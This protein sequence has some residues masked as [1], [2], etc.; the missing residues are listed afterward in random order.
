MKHYKIV[1]ER[2]LNHLDYNFLTQPEA[3]FQLSVEK[4]LN[5]GWNLVGGIS[6]AI[7]RDGIIIYGQAL[8]KED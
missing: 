2:Q 5:S 4:Y 6:I 7:D 1:T 8:Y 3:K